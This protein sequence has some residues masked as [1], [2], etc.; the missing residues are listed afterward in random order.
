LKEGRKEGKRGKISQ[1]N[2]EKKETREGQKKPHSQKLVCTRGSKAT[3]TTMNF[4]D[5][6]KKPTNTGGIDETVKLA[7]GKLDGLVGMDEDGDM[8]KDYTW[9]CVVFGDGSL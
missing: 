1:K 7:G 5:A 2:N 6:N 3:T 9:D 4:V 8:Q